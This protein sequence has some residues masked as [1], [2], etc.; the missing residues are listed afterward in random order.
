MR[1]PRRRAAA[2]LLIG[3][4]L[5]GSLIAWAAPGGAGSAAH[6]PKVLERAPALAVV[7]VPST[8][9]P[10]TGFDPLSQRLDGS[11]LVSDLPDGRR[12]ELT[13]EPGLQA[14]LRKMLRDYTVPYGA[15]VAIEPATG[16][17][18][19]YVSHSS[20]NP[21]AGDLVRDASAPSAS[22]FKLVTAAALVDAAVLPDTRVCYGGGLKRLAL[23]DLLDNPA[24]DRTC[25]T[26]EQAIAGSINAVMAKLA[27]QKLDRVT[28]EH[29]ARAFGFGQA[30]AFD[31]PTQPSRAEVPDDRLELARTAA[32][33]WHMYM[34]PLQGALLAAT[35][36]N[37]GAM[38][39]PRMVER[40]L[41][42]EGH[43][44]YVSEPSPMRSVIPRATA[45][46]LGQ[47][48]LGTVVH[49]TARSAFHDSRGR[50]YLPGIAVAGKTG[51]LSSDRPYRAYSWWV[52]YA[53]EAAP[54]IAIATLVVNTPV[55]RIKA[56]QVAR[57]A[58]Q[59]YLVERK[60][61]Q[62]ARK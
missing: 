10:L 44:L 54:E 50:P 25:A 48:M 59:Y 29:Y 55:W 8:Q 33:F 36:A 41:D 61:V 39:R 45:K 26:L 23:A 57:E 53:P 38:P 15:A 13:L 31:A 35:I 58:L 7:R 16:R 42:R 20:A 9:P 5:S 46:T 4:A 17:V 19:A 3:A 37:A 60:A 22:I 28:I 34:S 43:E 40:V 27:D 1:A 21:E 12:A 52:G 6:A 14:H 62:Q 30:P 2:V 18:L 11:L 24:R 32:G 51:S 47:M 49:G 56:S